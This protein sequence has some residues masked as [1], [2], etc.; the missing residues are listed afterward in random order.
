MKEEHFEQLELEK[1]QQIIDQIKQTDAGFNYEEFKKIVQYTG[2]LAIEMNSS[3]NEEELLRLQSHASAH[4][5]NRFLID[6][7]LRIP[8]NTHR[9]YDNA[10]VEEIYLDKIIPLSDH[11]EIKVVVIVRYNLLHRERINPVDF[12][13]S[14]F[15]IKQKM[16]L[17]YSRYREQTAAEQESKETLCEWCDSPIDVGDE[18]CS[19]CEHY[20]YVRYNVWMLHDKQ[21]IDYIYINKKA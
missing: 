1:L 6:E 17:T 2:K 20:V 15:E 8:R 16:E 21:F 3:F 13:D 18:W 12:K 4:F 9:F 14:S 19:V 7:P 10:A 5:F 11:D